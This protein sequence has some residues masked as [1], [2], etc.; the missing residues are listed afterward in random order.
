MEQGDGQPAEASGRGADGAGEDHCPTSV[1]AG[2]CRTEEYSVRPVLTER[3][4]VNQANTDLCIVV[5][6]QRFRTI[7]YDRVDV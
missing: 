1:G 3:P 2:S 6:C 7:H 5:L 4:A